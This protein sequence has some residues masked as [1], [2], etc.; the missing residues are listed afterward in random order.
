MT[1]KSRPPVVC[2]LSFFIFI[3]KLNI[4]KKDRTLATTGREISTGGRDTDR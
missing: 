2:L 4:K 1:D 3:F